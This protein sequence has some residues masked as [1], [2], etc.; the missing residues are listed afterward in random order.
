MAPLELLAPTRGWSSR[1]STPCSR[2]KASAYPQLPVRAGITRKRPA[3]SQVFYPECQPVATHLRL[4]LNGTV[5]SRCSG[6]PLR[7]KAA[8]LA[9]F[10]WARVAPARAL[11]LKGWSAPWPVK[12]KRRSSGALPMFRRW[13]RTERTE[14][15]NRIWRRGER[16][17][18]G[19]WR[20]GKISREKAQNAQSGEA[21]TR[22][23]TAEHAEYAERKPARLG[24]PRIPRV[25]RFLLSVR[26]LRSLRANWAIAMQK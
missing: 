13:C 17:A 2:A 4:R 14:R 24:I 25:P 19:R 11:P 3:I 10:S 12:G 21:P 5:R 1:V 18:E 22:V 20:R 16:W 23:I 7:K 8:W 26:P 6:S 9:S 15:T